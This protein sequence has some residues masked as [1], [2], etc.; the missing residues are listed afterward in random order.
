MSSK[1]QTD[2]NK[3]LIFN[4]LNELEKHV[5]KNL[6]VVDTDQQLESEIIISGPTLP[7][8]TRIKILRVGSQPP[9]TFIN[10]EYE[11][12]RW[13]PRLSINTEHLPWK[14]RKIPEKEKI[15]PYA[16]FWK[17]IPDY[18]SPPQ[19]SSAKVLFHI[20]RAVEVVLS[21]REKAD[22]KESKFGIGLN[23]PWQSDSSF[24]EQRLKGPNPMSIKN[25]N[26][27]NLNAFLNK[28][29]TTE[30]CVEIM[31]TLE[32]TSDKNIFV[33][34]YSWLKDFNQNPNQNGGR[35]PATVAVFVFTGK[36]LFPLWIILCRDNINSICLKNPN[37]SFDYYS[38]TQSKPWN[39]AKKCVQCSD[40]N[41]HE[42]GHHLIRTHFITFYHL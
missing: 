26:K 20:N 35:V 7:K 39:F 27:N 30:R 29:L 6:P 40:F 24:A 37:T 33:I 32:K 3:V 41:V 36:Y 1:Q 4:S 2:V 17:A 12:E 16:C 21:K 9:P 14:I 34:D 23:N 28:I 25:M 31:N 11:L 18:F 38:T 5:N 8:V 42:I 13:N 10:H 22:S 19:Q 15:P